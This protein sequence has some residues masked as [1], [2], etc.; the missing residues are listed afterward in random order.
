MQLGF[1]IRMAIAIIGNYLQTET[2]LYD[3]KIR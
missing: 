3:F 2:A 1:F